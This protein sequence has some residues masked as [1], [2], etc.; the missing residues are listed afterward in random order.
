MKRRLFYAMPNLFE[1][2]KCLRSEITVAEKI[3]WSCLVNKQLNGY[4][5][6]RRHP[7]A[8]FV[9]DF[10]CHKAKLDIEIDSGISQEREEAK[11]NAY[12]TS[13]LKSR[14]II[15]IRFMDEEVICK[16]DQVIEKIKEAITKNISLQG[17]EEQHYENVNHS[18]RSIR[19]GII[20]FNLATSSYYQ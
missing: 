8:G 10:Y 6:K 4:R 20:F 14:G 18:S 7:V 2:E 15:V 19:K 16:T 11:Y 5:F 1:N 12:R 13:A 9:A 3:L 17:I